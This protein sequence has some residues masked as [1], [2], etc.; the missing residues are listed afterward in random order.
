MGA[1]YGQLVIPERWLAVLEL[2]EVIER[3]ATDLV[4]PIPHDS[5]SRS[6]SGQESEREFWD[7][8][9]GC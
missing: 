7:R 6:E 9:P 1:A 5:E 4:S 2:R 8:Y 3:V